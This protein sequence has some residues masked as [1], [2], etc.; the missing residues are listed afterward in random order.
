M[1]V[2]QTFLLPVLRNAN[3]FVPNL[4]M[5]HPRGPTFFELAQQA[6][7]STTRGYDLLAPKFDYTPF[8][9]PDVVVQPAIERLVRSQAIDS[10]IDV[11]CGTGAGLQHLRPYVKQRLTGIDLSRGMLDVA[12]QNLS[13]CPGP[14]KVEFVQADALSL[15]FENEFDLAIC[16]GAHGH[17]LPRDERLFAAQIYKSLKPGGRFAFVTT[18]LPPLT[19]PVR[20]LAQGFNAAMCVRNLLIRPPFVMYY[21]TFLLPQAAQICEDEGFA[22]VV[23]ETCFSERLQPLKLVIATK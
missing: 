19:S 5:F 20:W 12:E 7:S 16:F 6:L 13:G 18:H 1:S 22:V 10:A 9:T 17:I 4:P 21:L 14:A 8:R 11:C 3:P 23:D 15:P 2:R